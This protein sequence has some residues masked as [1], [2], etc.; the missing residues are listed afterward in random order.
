MSFLLRVRVAALLLL[1]LVSVSCVSAPTAA[2]HDTRAAIEERDYLFARFMEKLPPS[3]R[4]LPAAQ[5]EARWL[6]DT[7]QKGAAAVGRVNRPLLP[8]WLNNRL[9]NSRH[10]LRERGL[11]WQYQHDLYRELRR[12][13]LR[14]FRLGCCVMD[15][16]EG[17]EHHCVYITAKG[18]RYPDAVVIDA[19]WNS[20]RLKIWL[21][22]TLERRECKDEPSATYFLNRTYPE[23]HQYP[24]EHWAKVK[25]GTGMRDYTYSNLPEGKATR[26]GQLMYRNMAEGLKRRNG[27]PTDY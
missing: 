6:A 9:V 3:Q 26:Q 22:S 16:G 20:G 8:A 11:C 19:W 17:S 25:C 12:R 27:K 4:S 14:Y 24:I 18:K 13:P 7:A 21:K 10:N 15:E 1:L 23:G 2:Y 5:Q